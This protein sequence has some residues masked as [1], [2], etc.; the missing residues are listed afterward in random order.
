M[1]FLT[2]SYWIFYTLLSHRSHGNW[3]W[4]ILAG[5]GVKEMSPRLIDCTKRSHL[6]TASCSWCTSSGALR[7]ILF[8]SELILVFD[9]LLDLIVWL[10]GALPLHLNNHNLRDQKQDDLNQSSK[11]DKNHETL[12][13]KRVF[14]SLTSCSDFFR[15]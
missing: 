13:L 12:L 11:S 2:I 3:W 14:I 7:N 6:S 8:Y 15:T 10:G 5:Q 4:P 9:T 1:R